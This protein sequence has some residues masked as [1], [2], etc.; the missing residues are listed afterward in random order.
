VAARDMSMTTRP[1]GPPHSV[2]EDAN[3]ASGSGIDPVGCSY[4]GSPPYRLIGSMPLSPIRR[5]FGIRNEPP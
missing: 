3:N 1:I 5:L 4:R 2:C